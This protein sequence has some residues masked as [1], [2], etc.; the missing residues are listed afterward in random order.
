LYFGAGDDKAQKLI[1]LAYYIIF[2]NLQIWPAMSYIQRWKF[3]CLCFIQIHISEPIWTKLCTHLPLRLEETV[4]YVCS[5]NVGPFSTFLT[6]FIGSECRILGTKWLPAQD[7]FATALYPWFFAGVSVTSRKWR[8]SRRRLPRVICDSV[9]SVIL[10]GVRVMSRKWR[11]SRRH[12][13]VLIG[14]VVH[15]G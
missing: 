10:A 11:C 2:R 3:V 14:S 13:R 4:R 1:R 15:Y 7:T 12:L 5:E 6:F 9:I 8:F